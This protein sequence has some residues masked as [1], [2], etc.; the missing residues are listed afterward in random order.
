MQMRQKLAPYSFISFCSAHIGML[1]QCYVL[2]ILDTHN[3]SKLSAFFISPEYNF[4][5][6][7][8]T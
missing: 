4:L 6:Y 1:Y 2:H 8:V 5:I 7:F 3:T